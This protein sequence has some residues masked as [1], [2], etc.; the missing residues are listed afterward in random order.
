MGQVDNPFTKSAPEPVFLS[1]YSR[2]TS[3][4][5]RRKTS[6]LQHLTVKMW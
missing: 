5:L 3:T 6:T 4:L 2:K 1:L